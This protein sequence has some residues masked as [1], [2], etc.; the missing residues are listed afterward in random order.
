MIRSL[1]GESFSIGS[2]SP[3]SYIIVNAMIDLLMY[4]TAQDFPSFLVKVLYYLQYDKLY[5]LFSI[6]RAAI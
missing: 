2:S 1:F 4:G 6:S 5:C 3:S